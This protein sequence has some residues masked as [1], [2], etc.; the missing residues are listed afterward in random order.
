[1]KTHLIANRTP[2]KDRNSVC[3]A[4]LTPLFINLPNKYS[5]VLELLNP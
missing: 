4:K 1:M 2:V 5:E 3:L